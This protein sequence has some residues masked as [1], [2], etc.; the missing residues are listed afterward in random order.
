MRMCCHL[1]VKLIPAADPQQCFGLNTEETYLR[2]GLIGGVHSN[3]WHVPVIDVLVAVPHAVDQV[4]LV[5]KLELL[6]SV[7]L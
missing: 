5:S 7:L 1:L 2:R 4:S 3:L 6:E